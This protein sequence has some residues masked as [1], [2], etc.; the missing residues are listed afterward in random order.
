MAEWMILLVAVAE[1]DSER[2]EV[3]VAVALIVRPWLG[4]RVGVRVRLRPEANGEKAQKKTINSTS[5]TILLAA[6]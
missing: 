4:L 6:Q 5:F 3:A 1:N 2:L